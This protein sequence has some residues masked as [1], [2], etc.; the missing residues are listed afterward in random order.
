MT[1]E[2]FNYP[3]EPSFIF[4]QVRR[5]FLTSL[6]TLPPHHLEPVVA[7]ETYPSREA[8]VARLK[9]YAFSQGY[10]AVGE[11]GGP[12]RAKLRCCQQ[13]KETRNTRK[14]AEADRKRKTKTQASDCPYRV[15]AANKKQKDGHHSWTIGITN[16]THNHPPLADPF[17]HPQTKKRHPKYSQTYHDF[18]RD[19]Q[20]GISYRQATAI[21]GEDDYQM[22]RKAYYNIRG[23]ARTERPNKRRKT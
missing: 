9:D 18:Q 19:R 17:G 7:G 5:A 3:S 15:Y 6:E 23:P 14:L 20:R 8:A 12:N 11:G 1:T 2:S 21:V 4:P 13:G 22:S 16:P 10:V